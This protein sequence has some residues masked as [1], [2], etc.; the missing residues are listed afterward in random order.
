MRKET[1]SVRLSQKLYDDVEKAVIKETTEK[2][3]IISIS[4]YVRAAIN[5]HV[6]G[7]LNL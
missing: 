2:N 7:S 4:S 3:K 5:N 1:L 6:S